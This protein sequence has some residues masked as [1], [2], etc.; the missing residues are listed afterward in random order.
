MGDTVYV[1]DTKSSVFAI[2]R[3]TGALR[4]ARKYAAPNDGPNGVA[5]ADGRVFAATD[6]TAFALHADTGK[7]LWSQRLTDV[8]EQFV[9]IA[10][11][12]DDGRVYLSTVGF[13][14]GGRGAL[15]ALDAETGR[16]VWKFDTIKEPWPD[17]FAGGGGAWN[18]LSVDDERATCTPASRTPGPWGGSEE[19]PERGLVPG[20]HALHRFA[21]RCSRERP[22]SSSGTTRCCRTTC[23][24]TTS[25]VSPILA[26]LDG[27][28]DVVFG[29]GKAARVIAWDR[30]RRTSGCG[31]R[32]V[33]PHRNDTG[34]LPTAAGHASAP[35]SSAAC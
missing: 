25:S 2:D 5:V 17:P 20:Q 23:A 28:R 32:P 22:G 26:R 19:V 1:Q 27:G 35:G 9:D 18:P 34:P 11:V 13:A 31:S 12:V 7:R 6:T 29:A 24:T 10:P 8:N 4:W 33:G 30:R 21:R 3:E 14:P 16:Q 15:Y